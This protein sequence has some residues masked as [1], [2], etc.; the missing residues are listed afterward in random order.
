MTSIL[1]ENNIVLNAAFSQKEDAIRAAGDLLLNR[2][3]ITEKYIDYMLQRENVVSTYLGNNLA[4]PHGIA[5]SENEIIRSGIAVIQIPA[6]VSFGEENIAHIVIG[7]AGKNG[8]HMD[9]LNQIAVVCMEEENVQK[10]RH[11]TNKTEILN[12]LGI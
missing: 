12:L 7:I 8:S 9:I 6:G 10:M 4:L 5:G 3:Y 11:A 1:N 2:G